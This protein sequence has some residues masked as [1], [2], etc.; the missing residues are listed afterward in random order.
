[1]DDDDMMSRIKH[2]I[3]MCLLLSDRRTAI[4]TKTTS[5][6]IWNYLFI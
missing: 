4:K 2:L 3:S 6:I 5:I 1:M